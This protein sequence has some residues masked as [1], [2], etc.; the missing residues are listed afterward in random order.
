VRFWIS[1]RDSLIPVGNLTHHHLDLASIPKANIY[2][3]V[4]FCFLG[5]IFIVS[6]D[7]LDHLDHLDHLDL[8]GL[9]GRRA[10]G[11]LSLGVEDWLGLLRRRGVGFN[12]VVSF[13]DGESS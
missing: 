1:N 3:F 13:K 12:P 10:D 8:A 11:I 2:L 7:S 9:L 6:L 4:F 5:F